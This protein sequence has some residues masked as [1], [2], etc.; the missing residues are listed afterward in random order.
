MAAQFAGFLASLTLLSRADIYGYTCSM[1]IRIFI[2]LGFLFIGSLMSWRYLQF[3]HEL[4]CGGAILAWCPEELA[5]M[6]E[7]RPLRYIPEMHW[8]QE[9]VTM[10]RCSRLAGKIF[11]YGQRKRLRFHK[12][13][14]RTKPWLRIGKT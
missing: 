12:I 5:L 11:V 6:R 14:H 8:T 7:L 4:N 2:L 13:F 9:G 3:R 10:P 1:K